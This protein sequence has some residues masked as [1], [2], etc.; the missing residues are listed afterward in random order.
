MKEKASQETKD[1]KLRKHYSQSPEI[2]FFIHDDVKSS[3]SSEIVAVGQI[4]GHDVL[5]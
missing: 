3:R 5:T 2:I 1:F 4:K